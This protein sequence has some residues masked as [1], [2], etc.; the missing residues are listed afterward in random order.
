MPS[1]CLG[2]NQGRFRNGLRSFRDLHMSVLLIFIGQAVIYFS[3]LSWAAWLGRSP[4]VNFSSD[5]N[6]AKYRIAKF[7]RIPNP[8]LWILAWTYKPKVSKF[9]FGGGETESR[10][11]NLAL[12]PWS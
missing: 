6:A 1:E 3:A 2:M 10:I 4:N 5:F 8:W 9:F 12:D 7:G 11:C